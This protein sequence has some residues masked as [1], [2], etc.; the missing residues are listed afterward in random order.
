[1]GYRNYSTANG[2]IVDP[3]GNGDF[4]TISAA[5]TAAVSGDTIFIRPSTYTENPTLKAGVNLVAFEPTF[6][7]ADDI[8]TLPNVIINGKCTFTAAGN[9]GISGI[10]LQTNSDFALAVTGSAASVVIL[11]ECFLYCLNN[12]GISFTSSSASATIQLNYSGGD[13]ATTGIALFSHSSAGNLRFQNSSFS[14]TGTSL[15]ANTVS[16]TGAFLPNIS[17]WA[18]GT[19]FSSSGGMNGNFLGMTMSGNQTAL[20]ISGSATASLNLQN[21][22]MTSGTSSCINIGANGS[23]SLHNCFLSSSN[24]NTITGTGSLSFTE[25]TFNSTAN[26]NSTLTLSETTSNI[27]LGAGGVGTTGQVLTSNGASSPPTFQAAGG[28]SFAVQQV[29]A[30]TTSNASITST[31]S[32][33][34]IPTTSGGTQVLSVAIT[35]TNSSHVLV[36]EYTYFCVY[37][38]G[39]NADGSQI[40]GIFQDAT[41]N[42]LYGQIDASF[43]N[44]NGATQIQSGG[45]VTGRYYMT[46]GTTSSTTFKV[47]IGVTTGTAFFLENKAGSTLGGVQFGSITVTE[48]TS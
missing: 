9:V 23:V 27:F 14:N 31:F 30:N 21:T 32:I 43:Y 18:N 40:S 5:L 29:R 4:K 33:G 37:E 1:M 35:P 19:T 42:A 48:Y 11:D 15:T 45:A 8:A 13:L 7:F 2:L 16:G 28:S 38:V 26:I 39:L 10:G 24:A 12:T 3:S 44:N 36:I 25:I 41:A 22:T 46:A 6:T 17:L 20:T 47:R 34:S